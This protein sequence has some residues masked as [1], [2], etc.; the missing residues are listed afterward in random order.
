MM[1]LHRFIATRIIRVT[2]KAGNEMKLY[3]E[4][5]FS[6]LVKGET[7]RRYNFAAIKR[8]LLQPGASG[9]RNMK[10]ILFAE[11]NEVLHWKTNVLA[12][13]KI[14]GDASFGRVL[15]SWNR[16]SIGL[17]NPETLILQNSR[18]PKPQDLKISRPRY[19]KTP[20]SQDLKASRLQDPSNCESEDRKNKNAVASSR[21]ERTEAEIRGSLHPCSLPQ[22]NMKSKMAPCSIQH[23]NLS[24]KDCQD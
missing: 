22:S 17:W 18:I 7:A 5:N 1:P 20:K 13:L 8:Q 3:S 15:D 14:W 24:S 9:L 19:S 11:A 4:K 6:S 16:W 12:F 23:T 2:L 10:C 21:I